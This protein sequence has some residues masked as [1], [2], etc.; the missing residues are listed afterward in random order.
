MP[1]SEIERLAGDGLQPT[2]RFV[3]TLREDLRGEWRGETRVVTAPAPHR[4]WVVTAGIVA[5]AAAIVG[6]GLLAARPDDRDVIVAV[7]TT[8]EPT[9]TGSSAGLPTTGL[10][11]SAMEQLW[12]VT[13]VD[14]TPFEGPDMPTFTPHAD[15]TITGW[16]GCNH[17]EITSDGG[18]GTVAGCP[19][20]VTPVTAHGPFTM[21]SL[22]ELRT[23]RFTAMTFDRQRDE[24]APAHRL[25]HTYRYGELGSFALRGDG[26]MTLDHGG[27]EMVIG[28][29]WRSTAVFLTLAVQTSLSCANLDPAFQAWF[30]SVNGVDTPYVFRD[31]DAAGLWM[32]TVDRVTRLEVVPALDGVP[33]AAVGIDW[34]LTEIDGALYVPST[35]IPSFR[36]DAQGEVSGFDGCERYSPGS[37]GL[38]DCTGTTTVRIT[39]GPFEL[40]ADGRLLAGGFGAVPFAPSTSLGSAD[41]VGNWRFDAQD[42]ILFNADGSFMGGHPDC[43]VAGTYTVDRDGL[44]LGVQSPLACPGGTD[45]EDWLQAVAFSVQPAG[46]QPHDRGNRLELW[47]MTAQGAVTRLGRS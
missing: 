33:A 26:R 44:R 20:G 15:G 32:R 29:T 22:H 36:F 40:L 46:I 7:E 37:E 25:D 38:N 23:S 28:G 45:F 6:I 10:P 3:A 14:G 4:P 43:L 9:A 24:P 19:A 17:Y 16:D 1:D 34:V 39:S 18:S 2:E 31:G 21:N 42:S 12:V 13:S 30:E 35:N 47:V 5:A 27:C 8:A 41:V 11:A